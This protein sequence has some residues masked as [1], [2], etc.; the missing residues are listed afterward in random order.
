M[1]E[2]GR[3]EGAMPC[4]EKCAR[5]G[6]REGPN[7]SIFK[8]RLN[9]NKRDGTIDGREARRNGMT[10]ERVVLGGYVI[11]KGLFSNSFISF[12]INWL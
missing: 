12:F 1:P 2:K 6:L 8:Y 10:V 5:P 4:V 3:T 11:Q 7:A 9:V